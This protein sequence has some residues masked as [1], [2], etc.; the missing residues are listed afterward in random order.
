[1]TTSSTSSTTTAFL[2]DFVGVSGASLEVIIGAFTF[3]I[4]ALVFLVLWTTGCFFLAGVFGGA[5]FN[6][7]NSFANCAA[8]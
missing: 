8:A 4:F 7:Y 2:G 3:G 5:G 6:V 1:M